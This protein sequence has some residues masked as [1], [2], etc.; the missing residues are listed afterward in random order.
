[1]TTWTLFLDESGKYEGEYVPGA[2]RE[3]HAV[4]AGGILCPGAAI[5]LDSSWRQAIT[6][7][8]STIVYP[9]HAVR[10]G[11]DVRA[12]LY[13]TAAREIEAAGAIWIF[14]VDVPPTG[15]PEQE[16]V[17]YVR[18]LADVVDLAGRIAA[19]EGARS[20]DLRPAQRTV[21]IE[22]GLAE[23]ARTRGLAARNWPDGSVT[24]RTLAEV[25]TRQSLDALNRETVGT[26]GTWPT[27]ASVQVF[28]AESAQIHPGVAFADL[29][30]HYVYT[31]L[32]SHPDISFDDLCAPLTTKAGRAPVLV[33][34]GG[35]RALR[36][37]DRAL[38][39]VPADLVRAGRAIAMI[40][41][42]VE[43]N[44][45]SI[46]PHR[47]LREGT[48]H[49]ARYLWTSAIDVLGTLPDA[50]ISSITLQ[51]S[52]QSEVHLALKAGDYE[53]T[54]RALLDGWCG[55]TALAERAREG[56]T[57]RETAAVLWRI[58]L[59]CANHRGDLVS[60]AHAQTECEAI[61]SKGMSLALLSER[62]HVRNLANVQLQ[63]RLP[64]LTH[65][66]ADLRLALDREATALISAADDAGMVVELAAASPLGPP[67]ALKHAAP[68]IALWRALVNTDPEFRAPDYDRGKAYGTA[69]R[70][71]AF[72]GDLASAA[73][74][75]L[76]ARSYFGDSPRDLHFNAAVI[77]RIELERFRLHG[78]PAAPALVPAMT[79]SNALKLR[80]PRA[81]VDLVRVDRMSRFLVDLLLRALRLGALLPGLSREAWA[82]S[83]RKLG[84]DSLF[85][86]L[87]RGEYRSHPSELVA[88][89][90]G[91][92]LRV[93]GDEAGAER[94][95]ELSAALSE[96]GSP[97]D[98]TLRRF[99][100]F[101][102]RLAQDPNFTCHDLVGEI[103][104][105]PFE[106][107]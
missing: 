54:W 46:S 99:T 24:V 34:R 22:P 33:A 14:I 74:L 7:T 79:L 43:A 56:V 15:G 45:T 104:N 62:L 39:E 81:A 28:S 77:A 25:E 23:T 92:V 21:P 103:M 19:R 57:N 16:L 40:A 49:S 41:G 44:L 5:N 105:P 58:T 2:T 102:R 101:T 89:H 73:A 97:E 87:S 35:L 85:G 90:A 18:M 69:A 60:A 93:S 9:P 38:R 70:S 31:K 84:E 37:V 65:E 36:Q 3:R 55:S 12:D 82:I 83:L 4:L 10:L 64:A 78:G 59:A 88:R 6:R 47:A 86:T 63:N 100:P 95:F 71:R 17:A 29:G 61:F 106:Y 75:A 67:V 11:A 66:I 51:L 98:G 13:R 76:R 26:L 80:S 1:M 48:R 27:F 50:K 68:E 53:G 52:A 32:R 42:D 91:E 30:C 96:G 94:W 72:L 8:S 20:L 107:R